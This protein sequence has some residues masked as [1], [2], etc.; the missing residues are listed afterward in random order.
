MDDDTPTIFSLIYIDKMLKDAKRR[1]HIHLMM[2]ARRS[3]P[4]RDAS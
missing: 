1:G 4:A 3:C 2:S